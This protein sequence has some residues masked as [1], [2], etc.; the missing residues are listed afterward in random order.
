MLYNYQIIDKSG[1]KNTGSIETVS[2]DVAVN[3]L[4]RRGFVIVSIE[5]A[6]KKSILKLTLFERVSNRDIVILSRQI[7]TLFEAQVSALRVFRLLASEAGSPLLERSL[8]EVGDD[9]QG[10]SSIANALEKHPKVFSPF[11]VNMVRSGEEAGTLAETFNYLASYLDRTYEVYSK[12][13][14]A[15]IYP[16]FVVLTFIVVMVLMLTLV[17]PRISV[18]FEEAGQELPLF[19]LLV[20]GLS[21]FLVQYGFLILIALVIGAFF[22]W[23]YGKTTEGSYA[24]A[25]LQI[26]TPYVGD[27]YKKLYLSRL[28]DNMSTML[29]SG[30]PMLRSLEITATVIDNKVFAEALNEATQSIKAGRPVSEALGSYEEIPG[31]MVQMIKVGEE[32]GELGNILATLAKFYQREVTNAV[33]TLVNLIEPVMIVAL[34]VGVGILLSAVLLPIYN[35]ASV[36]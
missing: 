2:M 36:V 11:Y 28:A 10:G 3:S 20:V 7:S 24:F 16:A 6:E 14:T 13:R 17:I 27:L 25:K 9:I 15:L 31:I 1:A 32:T 18:L 29:K 35:I 34:A 23:R 30:I 21:N 8:T 4:Q 33:D 5:P 19:T 12:A 26:G 22:L